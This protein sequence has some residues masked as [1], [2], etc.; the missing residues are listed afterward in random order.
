MKRIWVITIWLLQV[1]PA[2]AGMFD[3]I[4]ETLKTPEPSSSALSTD[5][6]ISGLKE[7]LTVGTK[8]AIGS[9]SENNG[10]LNNKE[11]AIPMPSSISNISDM[12]KT[13]GQ[14]DLVDNFVKSMNGAAESAAPQAQSIIL[15][16]I[17]NMNFNDAQQVL[18][19]GNTAATD[20]LK[21]KTYDKISNA[22]QPTISSSLDKVGGTANF[23]QMLDI[24]NNLPFMQAQP[25]DLNQYVTDEALGGL[26][27]VMGQEETKIRTDPTARATDLLKKVFTD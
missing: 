7:A 13:A 5:S 6:M 23:K 21:D 1:M 22:F 11:I 18:N 27:L 4:M 24:F 25:F 15:D 9:L 14:G 26:F 2:H 12:L 17:T 16:A 8:S 20:Y 19:G 3:S 10:Y